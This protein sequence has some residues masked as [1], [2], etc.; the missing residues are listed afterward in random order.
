MSVLGFLNPSY[1]G[2]ETDNLRHDRNKRVASLMGWSRYKLVGQV[3]IALLAVGLVTIFAFAY[4]FTTFVPWDDEGYFLLSYRDVLSG[5][6][7][8]DQVYSFYGPFTYLAAGLITGFDPTNVTHDYFRWTLLPLWILVALLLA[9]IVW[10]WTRRFSP[11]AAAFLLIGFRLKGLAKSIGHPQIWVILA[12]TVLLWLGLDWMYLPNKQRRGFWAGFVTG[13]IILCKINIGIFV[14]VGVGLAVSLQLRGRTRSLATGAL[15]T[16][17][18]GLGLLLFFEGSMASEKYFAIVYIASVAV[19]VCLAILRSGNHPRSLRGL[20]WLV[21]GVAICVGVGIGIT[22]ALGTTLRALS[23]SLVTESIAFARSYHNPFRLAT[24]GGSILLSAVAVGAAIGTLSWSRLSHRRSGW[25]GLFKVGAGTGL[26]FAFSYNYGLALAGSLLFLWL[27]IVDTRP[28]ADSAYSNRLLLAL[29]CPLFSLQLFPMAGEQVD[30]A[31]LL[32]I[33]AAAVLLGDGMNCIDRD[34]LTL[35][36]PRWARL[37]AGG[38]GSV[39]AILLFLF[40]SANT[41]VRFKQW[42]DAQP[43]NLPGTQWL[44]LQAAETTRLT[45]TVSELGQNCGAVLTVPGLY[46]FSLWSGVPPI[47]VKRVNTWPFLWPEEVR[48]NELPKLEREN[49]QC[50]LVSRAMYQFFQQ[51]A[52]SPGNDALLFEVQRTMKPIFTFQDLTLY[53]SSPVPA[54]FQIQ[55]N[56]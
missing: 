31:A 45:A 10:R 36:L 46:S 5:R 51:L 40:G 29:L 21:A 9:G 42:R 6:I 50:V 35:H 28:M 54:H 11:A 34:S 49:Q 13:I 1:E 26:L 2:R 18:V 19:T 3:I 44:R 55:Q 14:F 12:V 47:E 17:A 38:A 41:M 30:W 37:A 56:H 32:P 27:L 39:L 53:E 48:K 33:G 20:L 16:A 24:H 52:I 22:L 4:L 23:T 25:L 15:M 7:P 8:Y 43:V